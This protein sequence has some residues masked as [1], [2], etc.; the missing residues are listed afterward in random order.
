MKIQPHENSDAQIEANIEKMRS[1]VNDET[2]MKLWAV[3]EKAYASIAEGAKG[4]ALLNSAGVAALLAFVQAMAIKDA[5]L[6]T[7][8]KPWWLSSII[9]FLLGAI[10]STGVSIAISSRLTGRLLGLETRGVTTASKMVAVGA[11]SFFLGAASLVI[12]LATKF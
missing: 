1:L 9:F 4:F 3:E 11:F 10:N 8:M 5:I 6:L 12:G 2:V 7:Q